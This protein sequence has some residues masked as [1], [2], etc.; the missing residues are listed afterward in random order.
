[1]E[2][3]SRPTHTAQLLQD[4]LLR[5]DELRLAVAKQ[6]RR[7]GLPRDGRGRGR[8][9]GRVAQGCGVHSRE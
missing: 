5:L 1:M 7:W 4:V 2:L 9:R 3:I 6:H 8:G